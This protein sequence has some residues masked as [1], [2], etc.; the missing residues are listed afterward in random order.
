MSNLSFETLMDILGLFYPKGERLWLSFVFYPFYALKKWDLQFLALFAHK[1]NRTIINN[2]PM[3][4]KYHGNVS[5]CV[6]RSEILLIVFLS[7]L[8]SS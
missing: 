7:I 3:M 1:Q 5:C 2:I 4:L 8:S 6:V